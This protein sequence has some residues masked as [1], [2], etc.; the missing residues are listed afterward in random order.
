LRD[1]TINVLSGLTDAQYRDIRK[2]VINCI[3]ATDMAKHGEIL[4]KFKGSADNF[5]FDDANQRQLV[6]FSI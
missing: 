2:N 5:N 1:P 3:L 4:A 6:G